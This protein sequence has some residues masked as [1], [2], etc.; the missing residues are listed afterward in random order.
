MTTRRMSLALCAVLVLLGSA[1][2]Q[3]YSESLYSGMKYR[4]IGPF[5][6]GRVLAVTGV[7]SEPTT[8]YFGGV[9]GGVWKTVD[10]GNS[11]K[12]MTD[13][14]PISSVGAIAVSQ[15]NPSIVYVG[16]GESCIRG[17]ITEGDGM[18]KSE[19]GGKTWKDIGLKDTRHIGRILVHPQNPDIVYVAAL[20]HAFGPNAERG[21]FKTIDGGKTWQK[22]LFHDDKTGAIDLSFDP[23]NPNTIYASLW[24]AYRSPWMLSSGGPGS[25]LYKSTDAGAT[26]K[27]MGG[28]GFPK[29]PLG[30]IGISVSPNPERLYAAIEAPQGGIFRSDNGG[31]TWTAVSHDTRFTQRAWYYMHIFADTKDPDTVYVLNTGFYRSTDAGKTWSTIRGM[32]G[33]HHGLWIDPQNNQHL[34]NSN[35]GGADISLDGGKT[36]STQMNQPTAQFYHVA[37]DNRFRYYVYGAQQDNSTV[38]IASSTDGGSITTS[39]WYPVGG[40]ESGHIAP[41]LPNPNIVYAGSYDGLIT[42]YNKETGEMQDMNPWPDNPMGWAAGDLKYRFQWTAPIMFS[43]NDP[44][45][46]YH[47][48]NVLFR[49]TTGG[50]NWSIISPDLTRNDKSRQKS[51]GGPITQDNTSVEYYGTIFA[52]AESTVQKGLLWAGSDDGLIHISRNNGQSWDNVTPKDMPEWGTVSIIDA[53]PFDAGTA[54]VAVD[55]HRMDDQKPYLFRTTDFGKTWTMIVNGIPNA[56]S[57]THAIRQD[58]KAKNILYAGTESGV[59]VS[60]DDGARW[61][62]LKLNLPDTPVHDLLVKGDDLVVATHGRAF[63]ILDDLTPIRQLNGQIAGSEVHLYTPE[64]AIRTKTGRGFGFGGGGSVGANPMTGVIFDYYLKSEPKDPVSLE[65]TDSQGKVVRKLTSAPPP[66]RRRRVAANPEEAEFEEFFGPPEPRMPAKAGMNRFAWNMR[67]VAPENVPGFSMW[68]GRPVAPMGLPGRYTAK[69]TA[70]GQTVTASFEI[71]QDPRIKATPEDLQKQYQLSE[72]IA[73]KLGEANGTVEQMIDLQDQLN[74]LHER[75]THDA[76]AKSVLTAI[77]DLKKKIT[78]VEE[79]IIQTKSHASEDPLNFPVRLNNKLLDLGDTVDSASGA[80]TEQSFAVFDD[81]SRQLDVQ[82]NAWHEIVSKDVAA[83]NQLIHQQ[84]LP[85]VSVSA[86]SGK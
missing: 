51:S 59:F 77:D 61:Q 58:P 3:Q 20:G 68:G 78:P 48:A 6:G 34:I 65:I 13:K 21:V 7:S 38:A 60:W 43:P 37:V 71:V 1:V 14:Y 27:Q 18:Y 25:G 42:R 39:D 73:K 53:S 41:Y 74:E 24:E 83:L 50:Q 66:Q 12:P 49:S 15:S 40:G 57:W 9:S 5:R 23:T 35:D 28:Q 67:G 36:W 75:F 44:N 8:F 30:R 54:Y 22:V 16:T 81:L 86:E 17:N 52:L 56:G 84:N 47:A 69:L 33:D 26:W 29:G 11:W 46:L 76:N 63:W 72:Q 70:N 45:V 19:D 79:A 31:E 4:L 62:P 85:A 2:A 55:R 10:A 80:P 32:H 64:N 82:L